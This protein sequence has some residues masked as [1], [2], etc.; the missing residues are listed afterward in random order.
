M[1]PTLSWSS[2]ARSARL[3]LA[4]ILAVTA[5]ILAIGAP[6][7]S[8]STTVGQLFT[9]TITNCDPFTL[10]MTGV[11][12]GNSYTVP[13]PGVITSW[14]WQDGGLAVGGLKLKVGRSPDGV[15][16][17]I[18]GEAVA[19][20][21]SAN[22]VNTYLTQIP[23]L[24]GDKIGVYEGGGQCGSLGTP[25]DTYAFTTVDVP[26]NTTAPF[27]SDDGAKIPVA[28]T[29]EPDAD[30]DGFGDETQDKC[31]SDASNHGPCND[32]RVASIKS[33][34]GGRAKVRLNLPGAGKLAMR[35]TAK[36]AGKTSGVA[37]AHKGVAG[38]GMK[39]VTLKP[40]RRARKILSL[41]QR[42]RVKLS[43]TFTPTGGTTHTET[44]SLKL[45]R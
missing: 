18:V 28:A 32:F 1:P 25:S 23:V 45:T 5:P 2:G 33:L 22:S 11:A 19:G 4:S 36:A 8:A 42:L 35:E 43:I 20:P 39:I 14:S 41:R 29:V 9:P 7:A 3:R 26:A 15:N 12:A 31:P 17:T 10:I 40:N 27:V 21:Q 6:G 13:S 16:F 30:N 37:S 34:K 38:P 44:R 24:A